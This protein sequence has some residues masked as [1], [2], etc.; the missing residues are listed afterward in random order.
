MKIILSMIILTISS[1]SF[2]AVIKDECPESFTVTYYNISRGPLTKEIK[3]N[4]AFKLAWESVRE[5][6]RLLQ[7]FSL[8]KKSDADV[9]NYLNGNKKAYL[10]SSGEIEVLY[11]PYNEKLYFRTNVLSF[12][13]E[14]IELA[15]DENSKKIFGI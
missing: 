13:K 5:N 9:C 1:L 15:V 6:Q 8:V 2:A 11:I 3:D 7:I 14:Y 4:P 12:S 10:K